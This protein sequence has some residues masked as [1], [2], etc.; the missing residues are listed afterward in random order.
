MKNNMWR[1][2]IHMTLSVIFAAMLVGVII[3]IPIAVSAHHQIPGTD[4]QCTSP[5]NACT[6]ACMEGFGGNAYNDP[7]YAMCLDSCGLKLG[8][9]T[10]DSDRFSVLGWDMLF[11]S[12][13]IP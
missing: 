5:G 3:L 10:S 13:G 8:Q 4:G 11:M 2:H 6:F 12:G 7:Y 9:T 1:D